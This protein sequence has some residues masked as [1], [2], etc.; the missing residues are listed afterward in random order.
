LGG[1]IGA[2]PVVSVARSLALRVAPDA[3]M[4]GAEAAARDVKLATFAEAGA[5]LVL[6]PL[7]ALV[8]GGLLPRWFEKRAAVDGIPFER[9]GAVFSLA[10]P[11]WRSGVPAPWALAAGS[12]A[13]LGFAALLFWRRR[14]PSADRWRAPRPEPIVRLIATAAAWEVARRA[15]AGGSNPDFAPLCIVALLAAIPFFVQTFAHGARSRA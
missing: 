13:A 11:V 10:F 4:P 6:L 5:F 9:V 2:L 3:A 8:F 12:A 15:S 7:V 14:L 1:G